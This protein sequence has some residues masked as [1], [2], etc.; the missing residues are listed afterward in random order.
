MASEDEDASQ[1][2]REQLSGASGPVEGKNRRIYLL[3]TMC[4]LLA[5]VVPALQ[6]NSS[7]KAD[8]VTGSP[9]TVELVDFSAGEF[10]CEVDV[11]GSKMG[12]SKAK[13]L[14][15]SKHVQKVRAESQPTQLPQPSDSSPKSFDC[16]EGYSNWQRGWSNRK[17]HYCCAKGW[18]KACHPIPD[19]FDCEAGLSNWQKGWSADKE[20][21]C[22]KNRGAGCTSG[23]ATT[24]EP[25]DCDAG[26]ANFLIGWSLAKKNWCCAIKSKGCCNSRDK[27]KPFDC[28]KDFAVWQQLW[29]P[30]KMEWCCDHESKGCPGK[31]DCVKNKAQAHRLWSKEH[32]EWCCLNVKAACPNTDSTYECQ[33]GVA[34]AV[35][36]WASGK[37][38]WCCKH[39]KKG[40]NYLT[41]KATSDVGE[42]GIQWE[43]F[44][45]VKSVSA[46]LFAAL[47]DVKP[48]YILD[49]MGT[50]SSFIH[51]DSVDGLTAE[52]FD[53][54][55]QQ[56]PLELKF[57][58]PQEIVGNST[59][60]DCKA[61]LGQW[62]TSKK[63]WCCEHEKLGC[64]APQ[65]ISEYDCSAGFFN[66]RDG[67]STA[68]KAFCC[69]HT[70]KGCPT[71]FVCLRSAEDSW[72]GE[73]R[74]YCCQSVGYGCKSTTQL[75]YDCKTD[76]DTWQ[77]SWT[78]ERQNWCCTS[79]GRGCRSST[80]GEFKVIDTTSGGGAGPGSS[81]SEFDCAAGLSNWQKDWSPA[82]KKYCCTK[83][84]KGCE[85]ASALFDCAAGFSN[86]VKGWS[87]AKKQYC[88]KTVMKGCQVIST[89]Q[90]T[91]A[92]HVPAL[93]FDC[94]AGFSNW[95]TGWSPAQ[96]QY[97]CKTVKKG[98]Q[99][100]PAPQATP[101]RH[102]PSVTFDCAA[103]LS[104]WKKSWSPAKKQ[105]CCE[106][107][108]KG[109]LGMGE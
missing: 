41:V 99:V 65:N 88:C 82:K 23:A 47:H 55:M 56:R 66:W 45:T 108:M 84:G 58:V 64:G 13:K 36:G 38:Q 46:G 71:K 39:Y 78:P 62:S 40:C 73:E 93:P 106:T 83:M 63:A 103:G 68:K 8:Q 31:F 91:P 43:D 49:Q 34:N 67:W 109:C 42:L 12:W 22:C 85:A 61:D 30:E 96:K 14:W 16:D 81:G 51:V 76:F 101:A 54:D 11:A 79:F 33:D 29:K 50:N 17:K 90:A 7:R 44:N 59:T 70:A 28:S 77:T 52:T 48:G 86:W 3:L 60:Y 4:G 6:R 102:V 72:S 20:K 75:P 89:P 97:C 87:P 80:T 9:D 32:R 24:S 10:D 5:L 57:I 27:S 19:P 53:S 100:T 107:V 98:C 92:P 26:L 25:F 69:L 15:C 105:H 21:W 74:T 35:N 104:N 94:A 2:L 37:R 1:S 18:D 95:S